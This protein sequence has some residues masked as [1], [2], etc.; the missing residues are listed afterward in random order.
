MS[1]SSRALRLDGGADRGSPPA[2]ERVGALLWDMRGRWFGVSGQRGRAGRLGVVVLVTSSVV[3]AGTTPMASA[4]RT[5]SAKHIFMMVPVL[6]RLGPPAS[7]TRPAGTDAAAVQAVTACAVAQ[8]PEISG[9]VG[10]PG[11]PWPPVHATD[12]QVLPVR[13][14]TIRLLLAPLTESTTLGTPVGISARDVRNAKSAFAQGQGYTVD[15]TMTPSGLAKFNTM[16]QAGFDRAA[17]RN[18]VAIVIDGL[19]YA[20]PAF[21]TSSFA[22]PL[23]ITGDFNAQ[24]AARAATDINLARSLRR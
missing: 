24:Q 20:A 1:V 14:V 4:N 10:V 6:A 19:V 3:L 22:G 13:N 17:P 15:L 8:D 9:A 7:P 16:A 11:T 5:G 21:Q 18:E 12:C 23:Q 2:C